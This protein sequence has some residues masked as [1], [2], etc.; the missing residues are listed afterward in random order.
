M[1]RLTKA[2]FAYGQDDIL[3][4]ID[5][6]LTP[7]SFH[8]LTGASG[9]GKTTLLRLCYL[10]LLPKGGRVQVFGEDVRA[11]SRDDIAL[12]RRR[13]GVVHQDCKFLEHLSVAE[14]VLIPAQIA[15]LDIN[16]EAQKMRELMHW[17]GLGQHLNASPQELSGG[18][19]QRLALARALI[20]S[21]EMI[22][23]DEPTGNIDWEMGQKLLSL[24]ME[25]NKMGRTVMIATHD[26]NLIRAA[27]SG[28][29]A[30]VLRLQNRGLT[31]AGSE[32]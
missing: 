10:D 19:R 28:V 5:L 3:R 14:N 6:D 18:E 32:L 12:I 29:T 23:A 2:S 27:K 25:L 15:G 9:S 8:F 20:L 26:M 13:I 22:L 30:R 1:I 7:G 24:L 21:P 11:K 4:E 31:L 16:S 17:I